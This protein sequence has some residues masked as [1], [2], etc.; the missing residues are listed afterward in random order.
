MAGPTFGPSGLQIQT[1]D[2]IQADLSTY[3]QAQFG[4]SLQ[5]LNGKTVVGQL[6]SALAQTLV[7]YQEGIDAAY[8]ANTL[9]GADGVN[10]DRLVEALGLTRNVATSTIVG[11]T[12]ANSGGVAVVVPQGAII[13]LGATGA[14]FGVIASVTVPAGGNIAAQLGALVSGPTQVTAGQTTWQITT[15]ITNSSFLTLTNAADGAPGLDQESDAALRTRVLFSAHL[16]GNS[17]LEA[18]RAN[19]ADLDGIDAVRV[20]ENVNIATGITTPVAIPLLPGKS[21]VAVVAGSTAALPAVVAPV[22]YGHKPAGIATYGSTSTMV[23]DAEGYAVPIS[24]EQATGIEVYI[25][26]TLTGVSSTLYTAIATA[27]QTYVGNGGAASGVGIGGKLVKVALEAVIYDASKVNGVSTCT[28][29]TGLAF[30]IENPP[31]NTANLTMPWNQYPKITNL[32][33]ITIH[34]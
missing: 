33:H 11:V 5:T 14:Q 6:V 1:V 3:L 22:I 23:T 2:Q 9:D 4:A 10:L 17:T 7:T 15:P 20:Y 32:A 29:I 19:L 30:D 26:V 24:Y 18:I 8:Q 27:L 31:V 13:T 34:P 25:D 16:P 21:F 12:F 28:D